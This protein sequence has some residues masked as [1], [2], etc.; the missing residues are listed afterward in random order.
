[1]VHPDSFQIIEKMESITEPLEQI[2][3][4]KFRTSAAARA[5]F[6]QA[7]KLAETPFAGLVAEINVAHRDLKEITALCANDHYRDAASDFLF[8]GVPVR[9]RF[10]ACFHTIKAIVLDGTH[11]EIDWFAMGNAKDHAA[12]IEE[13][14]AVE[15]THTP[16]S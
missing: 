13:A 9:D 11:E 8:Y 15:T 14:L 5:A 2:P 1:M 7:I 3:L 10:V 4:E 16:P 12:Y 6:L